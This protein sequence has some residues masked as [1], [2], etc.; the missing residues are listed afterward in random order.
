MSVN[1]AIVSSRPDAAKAPL[2]R[3]VASFGTSGSPTSL[4]R[5]PLQFD[6][7]SI[8]RFLR[9]FFDSLGRLTE[10]GCRRPLQLRS[11]CRGRGG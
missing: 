5:N 3:G 9:E 6:L 1:F 11:F 2:G 7:S 10:S 4:C 8:K